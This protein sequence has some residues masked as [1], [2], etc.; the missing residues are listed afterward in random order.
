MQSAISAELYWDLRNTWDYS[1][2]LEAPNVQQCTS[3]LVS[4]LSPTRSALPFLVLS[5][6]VRYYQD[7][8]SCG[9]PSCERTRLVPFKACFFSFLEVPANIDRAQW[10]ETY[11]IGPGNISCTTCFSLKVPNG[12]KR[13][14]VV[15]T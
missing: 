9:G 13:S 3:L 1:C 5:L 14:H 2:N 4:P 6:R 10:E 12:L 8:T 11:G 15:E 7:A